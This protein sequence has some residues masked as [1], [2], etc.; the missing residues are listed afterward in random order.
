MSTPDNRP[1]GA[2]DPTLQDD[3][4][5]THNNI[6]AQFTTISNRLDLQ[7]STLAQHAQLL[8]GTKGSAASGATPPSQHGATS[9]VL[10]TH[11]PP[12]HDYR[13]DL[14]NTFHRPKINFP[15]Y[16]DNS[17][18]L[19]WLNRCESFFGGTRTLAVE[20]VWMASLHMDGTAV[21][22]F[23]AL[24]R[25]YGLMP[26]TRFAEFVNLRFGPPLRSNSLGELK[27]LRRTSSV[28]EYQR[29]F[30][31][32]LCRCEGLFVVHAM[33][34]FTTG[35]GEPMTSDVKMQRP[36]DLQFAMSLAQAFE[37]RA[38][39]TTPTATTRYPPRL[40]QTYAGT[41]ASAAPATSSTTPVPAASGSASSPAATTR[42]RFCRLSPD[43]MADKRKKG[44]CYF[45]PE[46]FSLDHKCASKGI[47]LMELD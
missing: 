35:L 11:H 34:L 37:H 21:E 22:C 28:E 27:E 26:W 7:G 31:A 24:E 25:E 19:P 40:R 45:C 5:R 23:Y 38:S 46:K 12:P 14:R 42:S 6:M 13:D 29:Q 43:E 18:P 30:L 8:E 9:S 2:T 44:G 3:L 20:Q 41:T 36:V 32:L 16:D 39:I 33:N 4:A 17:D 10:A 1:P 47:F 15:R